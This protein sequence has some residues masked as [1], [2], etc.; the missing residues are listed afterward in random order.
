M[1]G[2]GTVLAFCSLS[3]TCFEVSSITS[4]NIILWFVTCQVHTFP[5]YAVLCSVARLAG[6]RLINGYSFL[7]FLFFSCRS[8]WLLIRIWTMLP[9]MFPGFLYAFYLKNPMNWT[10][11]HPCETS[12]VVVLCQALPWQER[13]GVAFIFIPVFLY[14]YSWLCPTQ[15]FISFSPYNTAFYTAWFIFHCELMHGL[16]SAIVCAKKP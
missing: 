15:L 6:G 3:M 16:T 2:T 10:S 13:K 8:L 11:C 7:S 14:H 5:L 1:L 9:D 4:I 12:T